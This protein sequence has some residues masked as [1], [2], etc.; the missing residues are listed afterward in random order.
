MG[1]RK[2]RNATIITVVITIALVIVVA[3]LAISV[4]QDGLKLRNAIQ[5]GV[6]TTAERPQLAQLAPPPIPTDNTLNTEFARFASDVVVR[7]ES[8]SMDPPDGMDTVQV[9]DTPTGKNNAWV[10]KDANQIWIVF[11]GTATK[12]EWEKDFQFKQVPFLARMLNKNI[13]KLTYPRI[14]EKPQVQ[15][16]IFPDQD[17]QVHSGF[18]DIYM[19]LRDGIME[20][21][22]NA[23]Q[24]ICITG[25]SLGGAMAQLAVCDIANTLPQASINTVVF[26]C[27][28]VGNQ[29]FADKLNDL[30]QSNHFLIMANTCDMVTDVPLAVQPVLDPP[31]TPLV[32]VHPHN[33]H[34]FTDN[35]GTWIENHMM[36]VYVDYLD[37]IK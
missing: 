11:R 22:E 32:Y 15:A 7:L 26:G 28:R 13:S 33:T 20:S 37:S 12:D 25:H 27:P 17:M 18:M 29:P 14:I 9:L 4:M 21:L 31:S 6:G 36:G 35:R 19:N 8:N 1:R 3:C 23:T 30:P 34:N 2:W 10:L 5:L 24:E 16:D